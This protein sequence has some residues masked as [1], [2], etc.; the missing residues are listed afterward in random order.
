LPKLTEP[1]R[2]LVSVAQAAEYLGVSLRT[3]R[4]RI[5]AGDV[6]AYRFGRLIK[7]DLAELEAALKPL[8]TAVP[9]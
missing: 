1:P 8:P 2:Q 5:A 9:R 6:P 4:T 3:M 7:I